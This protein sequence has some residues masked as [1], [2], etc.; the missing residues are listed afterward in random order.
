MA[1]RLTAVLV[2][3]TLDFHLVRT[4]P[5]SIPAG[6]TSW[7]QWSQEKDRQTKERQG[8]ESREADVLGSVWALKERVQSANKY[9]VYMYKIV[10]NNNVQEKEGERRREGE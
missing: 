7:T 1:I 10:K 9:I 5:A 6:N 3:H 2:T 4:R 8:P